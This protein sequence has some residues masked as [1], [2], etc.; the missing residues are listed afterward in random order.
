MPRYRL[1][2]SQHIQPDPRK[3]INPRTK[4]PYSRVYRVTPA[5]IDPVTKQVT[6]PAH[7]PVFESD[8]PICAADPRKFMRLDP[9]EVPPTDDEVEGGYVNENEADNTP[10]A[11]AAPVAVMEAPPKHLAADLEAMTIA[12]L[13]ELAAEENIDVEGATTKGVIIRLILAET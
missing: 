8:S 2:A 5:E 7:F 3:G 11:G 13:R 6:K 10:A 1:L 12:Q 9:Q 4:K